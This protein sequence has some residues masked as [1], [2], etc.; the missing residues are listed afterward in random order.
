MLSNE[1]L[2]HRTITRKVRDGQQAGWEFECPICGYRARYIAR[3]HASSP[4]L[5]ILHIGDTQARHLSDQVQMK[6]TEH[7]PV[8]VMEIDE[9]D[10]DETWLTPQLRQQME[11]LLKDVNMDDWEVQQ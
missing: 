10:V 1:P 5:E 2:I 8:R 4:Q 7:Q 9:N 3:F 11:D 6:W